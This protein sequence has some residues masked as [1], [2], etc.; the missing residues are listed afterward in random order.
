[1]VCRE[2]TEL[3]QV[4]YAEFTLGVVARFSRDFPTRSY[5]RILA[6]LAAGNGV[7]KPPRKQDV[8]IIAEACWAAGVPVF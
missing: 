7:I 6:A 1:M 2:I 8:E 4:K 5:G 3:N